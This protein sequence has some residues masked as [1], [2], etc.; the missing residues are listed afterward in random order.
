MVA[1]TLSGIGSWDDLQKPGDLLVGG[2]RFPVEY[3]HR[4]INLTQSLCRQR[5]CDRLANDWLEQAYLARVS[6]LVFI[7]QLPE[8]DGLRS[9]PRF[10]DLAAQDWLSG[11]PCSNLQ[12][13]LGDDC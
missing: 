12:G 5:R 10:V 2:I 1:F 4:H 11:T 3:Q 6:E 9:D 8:L 13:Q 7:G